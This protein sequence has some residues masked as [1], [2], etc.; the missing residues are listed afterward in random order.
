[1]TALHIAASAREHLR[2]DS[3]LE[4]GA[5]HAESCFC[6]FEEALLLDEMRRVVRLEGNEHLVD[7]G[8]A[9]STEGISMASE[10]GQRSAREDDFVDAG[11][12][13]GSGVETA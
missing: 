11:S 2:R 10:R 12:C 3:L 9:G 13:C 6:D 7:A 8:D 1:M 5:P 4:K